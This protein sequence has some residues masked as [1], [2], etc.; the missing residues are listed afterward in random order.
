MQNTE[1]TIQRK[2][3]EF[4]VSDFQSKIG[5]PKS[6]I[7][8]AFTLAELM[9]A[10]VILIIILGIT[11]AVYKSASDAVQRTNGDVAINE[12]FATLTNQID[13]VMQN[14]DTSGYLV[15]Y[16]RELNTANSFLSEKTPDGKI[17]IS[18]MANAKFKA[19]SDTI[20]FFTT[21]DFQSLVTPGVRANAGWVYLGH[22]GSIT[23]ANMG[24]T[25][26]ELSPSATNP[27]VVNRWVL[28]RYMLLFTPGSVG[29]DY[30]NTSIGEQIQ[31]IATTIIDPSKPTTRTNFKNFWISN[32]SV[33]VPPTIDFT[34]NPPVTFPYTLPN[35]GSFKVEFA[36]P[37]SFPPSLNANKSNSQPEQFLN[38]GKIVWRDAI[39]PN[40]IRTYVSGTPASENADG[41]GDR[42]TGIINATDIP[43]GSE[44]I[45]IF[46]PNDPWPMY[47]RFTLRKY[48]ETLSVMSEDT[49]LEKRHGGMTMQYV[50][51][52]KPKN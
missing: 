22:A 36:M 2:T 39:I 13:T 44:G 19:R 9:V 31:N 46:G 10:M 23:P 3:W 40:P 5:N 14:I 51:K 1:Y 33:G 20:C 16:G 17:V 28:S 35:C 32:T 50:Y 21:G 15:I 8:P 26:F 18:S 41:F 29:N 12:D 6:K 38:D 7:S 49:E 45:V 37:A 48:D 30:R 25:P 4:K 52:L 11:G 34:S 24:T 47:I 27:L 42:P 43:S